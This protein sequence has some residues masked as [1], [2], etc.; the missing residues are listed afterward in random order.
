MMKIAGLSDDYGG[1]H[2]QLPYSFCMH[3]ANIKKIHKC[4]R[5]KQERFP[6]DFV[7]IEII[8]CSSKWFAMLK[9]QWEHVKEN[10]SQ[11]VEKVLFGEQLLVTLSRHDFHST[12]RIADKTA[13]SACQS[14]SK[15]CN[16]RSARQRNMFVQ[17]NSF[18]SCFSN[19]SK[20]RFQPA[21]SSD[22]GFAAIWAQD[23]STSVHFNQGS[24]PLWTK[25][26][27]IASAKSA[28]ASQNTTSD[29]PPGA[30]DSRRCRQTCYHA[31]GLV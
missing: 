22:D 12:A 30:N 20:H 7:E 8:S 19:T 5:V 11:S 26:G 31:H 4:I 17:K 9:A 1:Y 23:I 13:L 24:R 2:V 6:F 14:W 3:L 10:N 18:W 29:P 27:K 28:C 16:L 15:T 21:M 25:K